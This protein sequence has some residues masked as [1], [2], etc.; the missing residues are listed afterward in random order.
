MVNNIEDIDELNNLERFY[1]SYYNTQ[2]PNGYNIEP[3]GKN[4]NRPQTQE[5]KE[6]EAWSHGKLT[7][8]EVIE[9]RIAY[10][11]MESPLQIYRAKYI[12]RL[13]K[14]SFMNIWTGKRYSFVMPEVFEDN[15]PRKTKLNLELARQIR[16]EYAETGMT[17]Q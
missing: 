10:K 5:H 3:G 16:K 15:R 12:D 6:K 1:I 8:E 17:H 14:A 9:L 7:P 13:T 2:I 11:N 4:C